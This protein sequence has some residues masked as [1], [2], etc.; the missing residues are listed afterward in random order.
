MKDA[1]N[2]ETLIQVCMF[3]EV[4]RLRRPWGFSNLASSHRQWPGKS[5]IEAEQTIQR[6]QFTE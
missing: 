5:P 4:G 3:G 1:R 2:T 6:S